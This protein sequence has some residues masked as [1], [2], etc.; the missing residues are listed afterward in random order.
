MSED[1]FQP[2]LPY[3]GT[4]GWSGSDTSRRRAV[5]ADKSGV[6][7]RNQQLAMDLLAYKAV[8]GMT[9]FEFG[10]AVGKGHGTTSGVLSDLHK[11]GR[12]A[13]LKETRSGRKV[14]VLHEWVNGRD[15]EEHFGNKPRCCPNCGCEF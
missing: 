14:Y 15:T 4:S 11:D 13:R 6:T 12:I 2:S 5:N 9:Y 10:V 1:I 3:A 8:V 7:S